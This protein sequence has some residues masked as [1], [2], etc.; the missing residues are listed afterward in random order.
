MSSCRPRLLCVTISETRKLAGDRVPPTQPQK[1]EHDRPC[2]PC[3]PSGA[4]SEWP[5]VLGT[6]LRALALHRL[7]QLEKEPQVKE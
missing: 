3:V 7:A 1:A 2:L 5:P 6:P 4:V